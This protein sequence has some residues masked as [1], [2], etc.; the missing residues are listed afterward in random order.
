MKDREVTGLFQPRNIISYKLG[1]VFTGKEIREWIEF[2]TTHKTSKSKVAKTMKKYM[3]LDYNKEYRI[4]KNTYR[5]CGS[6]KK[7][8]F[9]VIP[10]KDLD[11]ERMWY[12][13][14]DVLARREEM[15]KDGEEWDDP[16]I[17][18]ED[19]LMLECMNDIENNDKYKLRGN[20]YGR[21]DS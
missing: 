17:S 21:M 15:F 8:Q 1:S 6:S 7:C 18:G 11:Y 14:K 5:S 12:V 10:K 19:G 3:N 13:M 16:V 2:H 20:K 4:T 9:I